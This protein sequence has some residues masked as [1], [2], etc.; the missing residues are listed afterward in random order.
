VAV[1]A[2]LYFGRTFEIREIGTA[3]FVYSTLIVAAGAFTASFIPAWRA[4][5]VSPSVAIRNQPK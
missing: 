2:A 5:Q 1:G 4:A 3:P